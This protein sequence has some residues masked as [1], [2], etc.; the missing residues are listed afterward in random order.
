MFVK[1]SE[2]GFKNIA[3]SVYWY[4]SEIVNDEFEFVSPLAL[5][6]LKYVILSI[7]NIV[8]SFF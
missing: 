6:L 1:V 4:K 8:S 7:E 2:P 3:I 5:Q